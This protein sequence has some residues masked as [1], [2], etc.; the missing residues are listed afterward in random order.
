MPLRGKSYDKFPKTKVVKIR[1]VVKLDGP[2]QKVGDGRS[3]TE[4]LFGGGKKK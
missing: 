2:K 3:W 4:I 1:G